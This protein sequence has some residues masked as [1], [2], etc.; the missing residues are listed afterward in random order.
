MVHAVNY[1]SHIIHSSQ[2]FVG[3][4][5]VS[6]ALL[7]GFKFSEEKRGEEDILLMWPWEMRT[8]FT[9]LLS[10]DRRFCLCLLHLLQRDDFHDRLGG[11]GVGGE[12]EG[13]RIHTGKNT[14]LVDSVIVTT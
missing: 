4:V 11:G 3:L 10:E 9:M 12:V 2:D 14:Q 13:G 7:P 5:G 1:I 6:P 8:I